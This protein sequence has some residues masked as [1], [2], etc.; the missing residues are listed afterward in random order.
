MVA[1]SLFGELARSCSED[2]AVIAALRELLQADDREPPKALRPLA[3][4][5]PRIICKAWRRF[6]IERGMPKHG[7]IYRW[8]LLPGESAGSG[9][10][11]YDRIDLK[12]G[13]PQLNGFWVKIQKPPVAVLDANGKKRKNTDWQRRA[14]RDGTP[15]HSIASVIIALCELEA[16]KCDPVSNFTTSPQVGWLA[17]LPSSRP[18]LTTMSGKPLDASARLTFLPSELTFESLIERLERTV[19]PSTTAAQ[20]LDRAR[21][22]IGRVIRAHTPYPTIELLGWENIYEDIQLLNRA[23]G[24]PISGSTQNSRFYAL[25]WLM[26]QA[27][28]EGSLKENLAQAVK[29]RK[30]VGSASDAPQPLNIHETRRLEHYV[31]GLQAAAQRAL[32]SGLAPGLAPVN[33]R[34]P[35]RIH[36]LEIHETTASPAG[37][38]M[39]FDFEVW[40][41]GQMA[42]VQAYG[43]SRR[44]FA[45]GIAA[46]VLLANQLAPRP[47]EL[48]ALCRDAVD[49]DTKRIL[50]KRHRQ[51]YVG[52]NRFAGRE[53]P[54]VVEGTKMS[55]RGRNRERSI[56]MTHEVA[57][58]LGTWLRERDAL[59]RTLGWKLPQSAHGG[60]IFPTLGGQLMTHKGLETLIY[61]IQDAAVGRRAWPQQ[62]RHT[63]ESIH[64]ARPKA[65]PSI[66]RTLGHTEATAKRDYIHPLDAQS[67]IA[68][69]LQEQVRA[70]VDAGASEYALIRPDHFKR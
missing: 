42:L 63:A 21:G 60:L 69:E 11:N 19:R 12:D 56:T 52:R 58:A 3:G 32:A 48:L 61:A 40:C 36:G 64:S 55:R 6:L 35:T 51:T 34:L 23:D 39:S 15:L 27:V 13:L 54:D 18:S 53:L 68:A 29:I 33:D 24:A 65:E 50:L 30:D 1:S 25:R 46:L 10:V 59:I 70:E 47:G 2:A 17:Q 37:E 31:M 45:S 22:L 9:R 7:V 38:T 44:Y 16:D 26:D 67:R 43:T 41:L 62:A 14:L 4:K 66:A 57:D 5:H 8:R 20:N 49:L 28:H